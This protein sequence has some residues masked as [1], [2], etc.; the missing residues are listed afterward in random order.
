MIFLNL[1]LYWFYVFLKNRVDNKDADQWKFLNFD[2]R[3]YLLAVLYFLFLLL[4]QVLV[5]FQRVIYLRYPLAIVYSLFEYH[6][7]ILHQFVRQYIFLALNEDAQTRLLSE[8]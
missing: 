1:T 5:L 7:T 6:L 8:Y 4:F 2:I 3:N